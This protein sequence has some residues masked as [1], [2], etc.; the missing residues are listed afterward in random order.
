MRENTLLPL[1]RETAFMVVDFETVT[2]RGRPPEPLELAAMRLL[3]G[4]VLDPDFQFSRLIRPPAD[5][6]LTAFDTQQTGIREQDIADVPDAATILHHFDECL[7]QDLPVLVAH[8]AH[9]EAA[10]FQRFAVCCPQASALSFL[11]TVALGKHLVPGL[12]N[13]KLDT[14][15]QHFHLPIPANR[16]RALPDVELTIQILQHLLRGYLEKVPQATI[17]DL[18]RIGGIKPPPAPE[19]PVQISLW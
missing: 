4:L 6:P 7:G 1:V 17:I 5:V 18:L 9:Y 3:P 13:Y 8:N 16:H 11:D 19:G 10:I 12:A 15:A 14:L 2:P